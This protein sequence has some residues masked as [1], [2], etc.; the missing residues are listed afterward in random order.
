MSGSFIENWVC[1]PVDFAIEQGVG[2]AI[3]GCSMRRAAWNGEMN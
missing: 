1:S 3:S 2:V